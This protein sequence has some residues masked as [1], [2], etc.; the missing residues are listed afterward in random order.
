[1]RITST[2]V[3]VLGDPPLGDGPADGSRVDGLAFVR[4]HT[5]EGL[6]GLSEIFCVPPGVAQ[7]VLHGP[8]SLFGR[9][10]VGEDP[11]HPERLWTKLYNSMLHGNRRGWVIICLGAVDVALWDLYG[12]AAD[13]PVWQLLGGGERS[14]H[15]ITTEDQRQAA[16]P[17]CTIVSDAWDRDSVLRQQVERVVALRKL[18]YR[19]FKIE[20]MRQTRKTIVELTRL[21]R[22]VVGP[23]AMLAV[24]V[25]YLWND[26][27]EALRTI[28]QTAQ[29]DLLF[30]ETP[31]PVDSI[32]A[33]AQLTARTPVPIAVGEHTTTRWE[34]LQLMDQ[35]GVSVAQPYMTTCGGLTEARRIVELA[36][37]R[38]ALVCPGNWST[39]VLGTA[40]LHLAAWSPVTPFYESAPADVYWSPLR[41]ALQA[42]APPVVNGTVAWPQA[43]GIGFELPAELETDFRVSGA[44]WA[45]HEPQ[46]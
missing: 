6:V 36:Q 35:G 45:Y 2:E 17:Y 16:V 15:Q 33:Y 13:R 24:D 42:V 19:G 11:I 41:K 43:A 4:I 21:T 31:F 22:E 7:A 32:D 27:G 18:G 20:P 28:E 8:D 29:Y 12:K 14:N 38:G 37:P 5:D 44:G 1:M 30:F 25:G 9:L 23:E 46:E 40:N 34:F 3:F 10:L 39:H 26:V